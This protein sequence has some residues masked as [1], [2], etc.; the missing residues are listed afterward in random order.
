MRSTLQPAADWGPAE[1]EHRREWLQAT[2]RKDPLAG[3][4]SHRRPRPPLQPRR[5]SH[6]PSEAPSQRHSVALFAPPP[7][8]RGQR[9]L[10]EVMRRHSAPHRSLGGGHVNEAA[11]GSCANVAEGS[12]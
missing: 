11:T 1:N 9:R 8:E 6:R 10:A 7:V 3:R 5:P 12:V 2:G 4:E